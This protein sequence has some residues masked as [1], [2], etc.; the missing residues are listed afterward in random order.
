MT[1]CGIQDEDRRAAMRAMHY[2]AIFGA[3]LD[4]LHA[5]EEE[6]EEEEEAAQ[7]SGWRG[8]LHAQLA[9]SRMAEAM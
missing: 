4:A 9:R 3:R 7:G 5:Q 6:E 2:D 8:A 1:L